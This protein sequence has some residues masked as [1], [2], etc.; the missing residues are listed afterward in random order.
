[1][2]RVKTQQLKKKRFIYFSE[3]YWS[4]VSNWLEQEE[5]EEPSNVIQF[6][7]FLPWVL[8]VTVRL[9]TVKL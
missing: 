5:K 6:Y 2:A 3:I 7:H 1:M 8:Q 4:L 9:S